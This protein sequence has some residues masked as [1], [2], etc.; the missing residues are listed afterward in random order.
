MIGEGEVHEEEPL[1][2]ESEAN[3]AASLLDELIHRMQ[4]EQDE[5]RGEVPQER[6]LTPGRD[7][8]GRDQWLSLYLTLHISI[9]YMQFTKLYYTH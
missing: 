4:Q 3:Q 2:E 8:G 5:E 7:R 1:N 9:H 6:P